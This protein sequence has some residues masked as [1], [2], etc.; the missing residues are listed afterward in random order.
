MIHCPKR[1][2]CKARRLDRYLKGLLHEAGMAPSQSCSPVSLPPD[3]TVQ[4]AQAVVGEVAEAVA[5]AQTLLMS[6]FTA[7]VGALEQPLVE[8]K[9]RISASQALT[10]RKPRQL[11]CAEVVNVELPGPDDGR[12]SP[13]TGRRH[14]SPLRLGNRCLRPSR[15]W[16][17]HHPFS[18]T[19][20]LAGSW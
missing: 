17:A 8:W 3:A 12:Y 2:A 6:K 20:D 18:P 10:V 16:V 13:G 19:R 1:N 14:G 15:W 9:A 4:R 7:S 11:R 5:D